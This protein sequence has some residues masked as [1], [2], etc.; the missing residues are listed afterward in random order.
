MSVRI[1]RSRFERRN[2]M[3]AR[4]S[5]QTQPRSD[6]GMKQRMPMAAVGWE[7]RPPCLRRFAPE[8]ERLRG[9]SR[10]RQLVLPIQPDLLPGLCFRVH[11]R[12]LRAL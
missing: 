4:T 1:S 2:P 5:A 11:L 12:H 7:H 9:A 8:R 10:G 6:S 3:G